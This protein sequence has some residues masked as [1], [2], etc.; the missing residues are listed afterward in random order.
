MIFMLICYAG[1]IFVALAFAGVFNRRKPAKRSR[2]SVSTFPSIP[3][4]KTSSALHPRRYPADILA[5]DELEYRDML[6]RNAGNPDR[7]PAP[8]RLPTPS[9]KLDHED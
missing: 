7:F 3:S 4:H 9:E 8:I 1:F 2:P 5:R 6:A